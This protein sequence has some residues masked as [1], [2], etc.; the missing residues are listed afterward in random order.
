MTTN[1]EKCDVHITL[2]IKS[3]PPAIADFTMR[4]RS[5]GGKSERSGTTWSEIISTMDADGVSQVWQARGAANFQKRP[6]TH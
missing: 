6:L 3:G 4:K 1:S 5:D 2:P